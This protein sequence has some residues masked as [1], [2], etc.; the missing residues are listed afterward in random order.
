MI[1]SLLKYIGYGAKNIANA[2]VL[3]QLIELE[4]Q[5]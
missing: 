1:G 3:K 5:C 2:K 4:P